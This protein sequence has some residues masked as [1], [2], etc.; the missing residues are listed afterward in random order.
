[1]CVLRLL[2]VLL[3]C[4]LLVCSVRVALG[5]GVGAGFV[6]LELSVCVVG[7]SRSV[8][9]GGVIGVELSC[10]RSVCV[11]VLNFEFLMFVH[12]Q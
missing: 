4:W 5:V 11:C 3:R 7:A 9:D 1:M 10:F 8:G 12:V 6:F 2:R